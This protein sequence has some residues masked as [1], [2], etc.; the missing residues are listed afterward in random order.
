MP[1]K[2]TAKALP[3]ATHDVAS[4]DAKTKGETIVEDSTVCTRAPV[5]PDEHP[6]YVLEPDKRVHEKSPEHVA[7]GEMEEK[8]PKGLQDRANLQASRILKAEPSLSSSPR[9]ATSC[10]YEG[11]K[12][13]RESKEMVRLSH[14][15]ERKMLDIQPQLASAKNAKNTS[16]PAEKQIYSPEAEGEVRHVM[17]NNSTVPEIPMLPL[18]QLL[19]QHVPADAGIGIQRTADDAL[20]S[21]SMLSSD[22]SRTHDRLNRWVHRLKSPRTL[23]VTKDNTLN[24]A[25]HSSGSESEN[26]ALQSEHSARANVTQA[27]TDGEPDLK[28]DSKLNIE[29]SNKELNRFS[30]ESKLRDCKNENFGGMHNSH[31]VNYT[32]R[33]RM[34]SSPTDMLQ[35]VVSKLK[36][37]PSLEDPGE[38]TFVHLD[39]EDFQV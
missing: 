17:P 22:S 30:T 13:G 24:V 33:I 29:E 7:Q 9:Y 39:N 23:R 34:A 36:D 28:S 37:V 35:P 18:D 6:D 38:L 8:T 11:E 26:A 16:I 12:D 27:R 5:A 21:S 15:E 19:Q 31:A 25:Q 2:K 4:R 20:T 10:S 32:P 3:L 1:K 14:E